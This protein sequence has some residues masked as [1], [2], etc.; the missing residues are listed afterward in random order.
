MRAAGR[1]V[2]SRDLLNQLLDLISAVP[3]VRSALQTRGEL[4]LIRTAQSA[5]LPRRRN[6]EEL[7]ELWIFCS[8][9]E[10]VFS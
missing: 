2:R 8:F 3:I 5:A 7:N 9:L 1:A 6:L 4:A 10:K